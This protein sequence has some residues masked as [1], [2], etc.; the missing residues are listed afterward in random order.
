MLPQE[1]AEMSN[2]QATRYIPAIIE[3]LK[4]IDPAKV[5]LF[6]SGAGGTT[7]ENSDLDLIVVTRSDKLPDSYQEKE[8]AYLEVAR[9]LRD[10]RRKVPVDLIVHTQPMHARF[11]ELNSLFAREVLQKGIVLYESHHP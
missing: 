3:R 2:D 1:L 8:N 4:E 11:I 6:G 10:I 9:L 5:I 7:T